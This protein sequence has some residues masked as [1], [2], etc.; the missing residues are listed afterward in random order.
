MSEPDEKEERPAQDPPRA[1]NPFLTFLIA[2]RWPLTALIFLGFFVALLAVFLHGGRKA[3][4]EATRETRSLAMEALDRTE[5][6]ASRFLEGTI[7]TTF[8]SSIPRFA[9][10]GNG[11]L[12]VASLNQSEILRSRDEQRI[13]WNKVH[14]G[15]TMSEIRV[16]VTY[17]Y[18]VNLNDPWLLTV[19]NQTCLVTAPPLR[20]SLPP[21]IHTDRMEKQSENGWARFNANEQ[22]AELEKSLSPTLSEFATNEVKIALVRNQA[23]GVIARFVRHWLLQ[24]E[25]WRTDRFRAIIVRFSD[26][27]PG[28]DDTP[29]TLRLDLERGETGS[30]APSSP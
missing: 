18:Y 13:L 2:W 28:A 30:A 1:E 9:D 26:E 15:T 10:T 16:P 4:S 29:P 17:R 5:N 6:I 7:T 22:M 3:V 20:P 14:L 25:H 8:L 24:E 12:E 23:R 21:A 19:S 27:S 11:R